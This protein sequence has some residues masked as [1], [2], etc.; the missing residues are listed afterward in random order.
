ME[1]FGLV[2]LIQL[3]ADSLNNR[4]PEAREAACSMVALI[5]EAFTEMEEQ[6]LEKWPIQFVSYSC[7]GHG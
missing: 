5:D 3:G 6:K 1:E 2:S 4:L 7:T